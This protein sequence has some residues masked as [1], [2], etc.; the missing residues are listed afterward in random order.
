MS[1]DEIR[2]RATEPDGANSQQG[3]FISRSNCCSG[4]REIDVKTHTGLTPIG[5]LMVQ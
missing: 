4:V 3:R 2:N 1:L 5:D